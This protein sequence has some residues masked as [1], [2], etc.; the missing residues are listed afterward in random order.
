MRLKWP[1]NRHITIGVA[2]FN[3]KRPPAGASPSDS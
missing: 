2:P 1:K 3:V